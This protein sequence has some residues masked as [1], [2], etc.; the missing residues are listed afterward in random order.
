MGDNDYGNFTCYSCKRILPEDPD[1]EP[2]HVLPP[3]SEGS[4]DV[5]VCRDCYH[6]CTFSCATCGENRLYT[7]GDQPMD[8]DGYSV[9]DDE[10]GA[11]PQDE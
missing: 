8:S 6:D 7:E 2:F 9:C 1:G 11:V 5:P 10:C 4:E 3:V